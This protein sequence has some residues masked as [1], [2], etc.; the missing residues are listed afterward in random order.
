M[1]MLSPSQCLIFWITNCTLRC[2]TN[3]NALAR[4][5]LGR[6]FFYPRC[7]LARTA[8]CRIFFLKS[9]M[10]PPPRPSKVK[11]SAP[12]VYKCFISDIKWCGI[13]VTQEGDKLSSC[14]F[15]INL[16]FWKQC[17]KFGGH[18]LPLLT[19]YSIKSNLK[20]GSIQGL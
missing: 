20:V 16:L 3:F 4:N 13:N 6:F 15:L 8:V 10:P 18:L 19:L 11:W 1:K 12:E 9:A 17:R 14:G 7:F 5:D 2:H